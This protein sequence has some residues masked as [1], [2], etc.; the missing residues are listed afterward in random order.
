VRWKGV[1]LA[2]AVILAAIPATYLVAATIW[3]N[4]GAHSLAYRKPE[5]F[6]AD[7]TFA[8][9]L[10]PGR[11][12]FF[13]LEMRGR[14]RRVAWSASLDRGSGH[15][16][17]EELFAREVRIR[18]LHGSGFRFRLRSRIEKPEPERLPG[19]GE[20]PAEQPE[21]PDPEE[22]EAAGGIPLLPPIPGFDGL[23]E[24]VRGTKPPWSIDIDHFAVEDVE[25]IW[26]DRYQ[27]LAEGG[28]GGTFTGVWSL[29]LRKSVELP[30]FDL[31]LERGRLHVEG[32]QL[33]KLDKGRVVGSLLPFPTRPYSLNE[34]ARFVKADF[35]IAA[36]D[37]DLSVLQYYLRGSPLELGG[38]G[39]IDAKL[40]LDRGVLGPGSLLE[41]KEA[42]LRFA[43]LSYWG[44]GEGAAEVRVLSEG[45]RHHTRMAARLE[46]FELGTLG[47]QAAHLRGKGLEIEAETPSLDLGE[48]RPNIRGEVRMP[49]TEVPDFRVYNQLWPESF[50]FELREGK[51]ELQ[52]RLFFETTETSHRADGTL[53]LT[54]SGIRAALLENEFVGDF[55]LDA[56]LSS[57]DLKSKIFELRGTRLEIT[58][59]EGKWQPETRGW[60][61]R[62][63]I[64]K[65][66]L[67]L[68]APRSFKITLEA[69]LADSSPLVAA[70]ITKKPELEWMSGLLNIKNLLLNTQADL[71]G[72]NLDM[73]HFRLKGGEHL[74]AEGRM[75]VHDKKGNAVFH[76]SYGPVAAA[77][78][79]RPDGTRAWKLLGSQQAFDTWLAELQRP[80]AG[81]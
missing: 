4:T 33:A 41:V 29:R 69:E 63:S 81:E 67:Q 62:V 21:P 40:F 7:W 36:H 23:G 31:Q 48:E 5:K 54:G 6:Q 70:L 46:T 9:T 51:A 53:L 44:K 65:G 57:E 13:G 22:V 52:S 25:E 27:Y 72:K 32:E 73:H 3:L 59:L 64:P 77:F 71:E 14:N 17:M 47:S 60:W 50:P 18:D 55:R 8:Y 56:K 20:P 39:R 38:Q 35:E 74:T 76:V 80:P 49:A 43:Y 24:P 79:L 34:L 10:W 61:A 2:V 1:F 28:G 26:L 12:S 75:V 68:E 19:P 66:Q 45:V 15:L 42:D 78:R 16:S 58:G 30:S 11:V 37:S